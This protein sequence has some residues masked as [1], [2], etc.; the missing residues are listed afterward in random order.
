[1]PAHALSHYPGTR[2]WLPFGLV[3]EAMPDDVRENL[4][5]H[6]P[7]PVSDMWVGCV[8]KRDGTCETR[9]CLTPR[10]TDRT[11]CGVSTSAGRESFL[12]VVLTEPPAAD[13]GVCRARRHNP[14][15]IGVIPRLSSRKPQSRLVMMRPR[16]EMGA[17]PPERK[18]FPSA[19]PAGGRRV[20]CAA[21]PLAVVRDRL[22]CRRR[23]AVSLPWVQ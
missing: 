15:R 11:V 16:D 1:M 9:R 10:T 13:R 7:P 18:T 5:A 4:L 12:V 14:T 2:V 22:A 20:S 6:V 21:L 17:V 23:V 19:Q 3:L 8:R